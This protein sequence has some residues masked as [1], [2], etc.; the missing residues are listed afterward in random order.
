VDNPTNTRAPFVEPSFA[1]IADAPAQFK[2]DDAPAAPAPPVDPD[3]PP[4]GVGMAFLAWMGS[5]GLLV[6]FQVI[7]VV[8]Y[9]VYRMSSGGMPQVSTPQEVEK[10]TLDPPLLLIATV[11]II[12]AHV[13]TFAMAW[14]II[15]GFGKRS[16]QQTV[17]WSWGTKFGFWRSAALAVLLLIVSG[18]IVYLGGGGDTDID[19]IVASSAAARYAIAF[20]AAATAPLVEEVIYRGILYP[21]LRRAAG[22]VTAVAIVSL[23][24]A[25]VHIYQYRNSLSIIAAILLL[26]ITLTA[27]RAYTRR[28]LPCFVMH[29][30]FNG[31][32]SVIIVASPYWEKFS[33]TSQPQG[34]VAALAFHLARLIY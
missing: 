32:Q 14:A 30:V 20:L 26:S 6:L 22:V 7:A 33:H 28:L 16:F 24:F 4:W 17:G 5:I 18:V 25:S 12:P 11:L 27:V 8:V 2:G 9:F 34:L 21:A 19:K 13:L 15:T 31:I 23:L 10:L 3:S 1:E 29:L